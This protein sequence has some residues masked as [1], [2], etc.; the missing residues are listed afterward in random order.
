MYAATGVEIE[1]HF[2]D[3]HFQDRLGPIVHSVEQVTAAPMYYDSVLV[4]VTATDMMSRM[5]TVSIHYHDGTSW[6][7]LE[8]TSTYDG[9]EAWI[10]AIDYGTTV[11]F[12][13]NASDQ[14]NQFTVDDNDGSYYSYIP[15]DDINPEITITSPI[16]TVEVELTV[17]IEIDADDA[18]SGV[19]FV[20]IYDGAI[21]LYNDTSAPYGFSWNTRTVTNGTHT[22]SAVVH[23][24]A[25]LTNTDEIEVDVQNDVA[26]PTLSS[27]MLNPSSPEHDDSVEVSVGVAD[28]TEVD[29]VLLYYKIGIG[30]WQSIEMTSASPLYSAEIPAADWDSLVQYYVVA[31]DTFGQTASM[32]SELSPYSYTV[33]DVTEPF[34]NVTS[35]ANGETVSGIVL[36][37]V[38]SS[39]AGSGVAYVEFYD[40]ATLLYNDTTSPYGYEWDTAATTRDAHTLTITAYDNAGLSASKE[41]IL[42][43]VQ[44][45]TW[46]P[47]FSEIQL[48]PENPQYGA[49]VQASLAITDESGIENAT[50]YY[51]IGDASWQSTSMTTSS[52]L[53]IATIPAAEWGT[54]MLYYVT[55]FDEAGNLGSVGN[56]SSPLSYTVGDAVLPVL[57]VSGPPSS[58]ILNGS[59]LFSV[60]GY[61][62]GSGVSEL[63]ILVNGVEEA[64]STT[65]PLSFLWDTTTVANGIYTLAFQIEDGA[66][67]IASVEIEYEV[68]NPE[69][70]NALLATFNNLMTE[71]G[72]FIGAGTIV[73][74]YIIGKLFSRRRAAKALAGESTKKPKKAKKTKK[75]S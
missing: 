33:V 65:V 24:Y 4:R 31:N 51:K 35:P 47:E 3:M 15:G 43:V 63:Q 29:T 37:S 1:A 61:D 40:G 14:S 27:I 73:G 17:D 16:D 11:L 64:S 56:E 68:N 71:Y 2:D 42:Y 28:F 8:T 55:S 36:I 41:I 32:G 5:G 20:E 34:V 58:T 10:P 66:G 13:A 44:S 25:G 67:N 9:F 39:D 7:V 74:L 30:D 72:F 69:G 60:S 70:I 50:L 22:I 23:D 26:P 59:I 45:D 57:S 18:G 46:A 75:K 38:E 49:S 52:S 21:L 48:S 12:Y 19:A 6:N 62:E 53:Y 54:I